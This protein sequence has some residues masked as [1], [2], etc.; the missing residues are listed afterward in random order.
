MLQV[1]L[2]FPSDSELQAKQCYENL[3]QIPKGM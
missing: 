3:R 2:L 1:F